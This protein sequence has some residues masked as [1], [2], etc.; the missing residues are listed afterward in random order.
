METNLQLEKQK[1]GKRVNLKEQIIDKAKIVKKY[2][3]GNKR[4]FIISTSAVFIL[5][6]SI[7][8]YSNYS[9]INSFNV[10]LDGKQ[11]GTVDNKRMIESWLSYEMMEAQAKYGS[12]ISFLDKE[13]T[14]E[15]AK[16][17][18]KV[19]NFRTINE[20][21]ARY[22][23]E[24]NAVEIVVDG[25]VV[26]AVKDETT[27]KKIIDQIKNS[28]QQK[29][30]EKDKVV[31]ASSGKIQR[32]DL[33]LESSEFKENIEIREKK[34]T[35]DKISD[36]KT[37]ATL[38]QKGTPIEKKYVVQDGDTISEIAQ[39]FG[40]T[41]KDIYQSNPSIKEEM[42][43][44][45]DELIV[46]PLKP[47]VTVQTREVLTQ[48]EPIPYQV[49][50]V[51]DSS[52]YEDESKVIVK[53]E[54]GKKEVKYSIV[55][56]NGIVTYKD[57][58]EKEIIEEPV[59]KKVAVGTKKVIAKYTPSIWP[60]SGRI[61]SPFGYRK[62]PFTGRTSY[63]NGVDIANSYGSPI[64]ATAYGK[65][66]FS[67]WNGGYGNEV[68]ID[69]GNGII[70]Y[71]GHN[72]KNVVQ[73]GDYVKRGQIIAYVGSTGRSTGPHV[74]YRVSLNGVKVNPVKYMN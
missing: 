52:M 3:E 47:L 64:Y 25:K 12:D 63:H 49:T 35:V 61:S 33:V 1:W 60:T 5:I 29:P 70:T 20:L 37:M 30:E 10:Y 27:A 48:I 15:K 59:T 68:I 45:G 38:L 17:D 28:Y 16:K 56:E 4:L 34:L 8:A 53:G 71:Y 42:I 32:V 55:K 6:F 26:G 46:T 24:A 65:V 36:E 7:V 43:Y 13:L 40:V 67:G 39:K 18:D 21:D 11:V 72:S 74:D 54:E 66:T 44:I 69:H 19:D 22:K 73:R 41:T 50:Y 14:F 9:S 23:I 51:K 62:D 31:A 58:I 2:I 57:I